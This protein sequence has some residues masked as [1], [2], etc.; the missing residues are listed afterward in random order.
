M[1]KKDLIS[2]NDLFKNYIFRI[3]DYQRGY[4]WTKAQ[5]IDFWEDLVNLDIDKTHYTGMLTIKILDKKSIKDS[6]EWIDESWLFAD[7]DYEVC[8][9]IDGQQRL[10]TSIILI[11]EILSQV[12]DDESFSAFNRTYDDF[13]RHFIVE[14][15]KGMESRKCYKF[16]YMSDENSFNFLK[17]DIFG[18]IGKESTESYYTHNMIYAKS[19]FAEKLLEY[20]EQG[21]SYETLFKKLI[22][23]FKF[24]VFPIDDDFEDVIAFETMNNRGKR[25]STLEIL[26]NRL[27]YIAS[28]IEMSDGDRSSLRKKINRAWSEIYRQLGKD[29]EHLLDDD[30]Y[31]RDHWILYYHE[32]SSRK[33]YDFASRLLN[34]H[35]SLRFTEGYISVEEPD[36]NS[37]PDI[38]A[39]SQEAEY[40]TESGEP[41]FQDVKPVKKHG[42]TNVD[43][44]KYVESIENLAKYWFY[45]HEP[46]E[47]KGIIDERMVFEINRINRAGVNYFKPLLMACLSSN[48][49]MDTKV[50]LLKEIEKFIFIYFRLSQNNAGSYKN[51]FYTLSS[52]LY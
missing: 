5:L 8:Y 50:E 32:Y 3:P 38:T 4:S 7:S 24:N 47:K 11:N 33:G 51:K 28:I 26:K 21:K 44:E 52:N 45:I 36:D 12:K 6:P 48:E 30:E 41:D 43:I 46:S 16:G 27:I 9:V 29:P 19:F 23:Y 31:L 20:K 10:T 1:F 15:K 40:D 18:H 35:F 2:L 34:D 13:Y 49:E 17:T 22:G 14:T 37:M 42:L 39:E 25:L